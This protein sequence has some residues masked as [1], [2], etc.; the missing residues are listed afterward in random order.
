MDRKLLFFDIDGTL[1]PTVD[2]Q[3][4]ESTIQAVKKAQE[5]GH[6]IF[7]N[8]GRC[9][10][11]IPKQLKDIDFDGYL[12][13]CGTYVTLHGEVLT[14]QV[15]D[16]KRGRKL[17]EHARNLNLV[18]LP[19]GNDSC[20]FDSLGPRNP[21]V[22]FTGSQI[23]KEFPDK[24]KDLNTVDNLAFCKFCAIVPTKEQLQELLEPFSDYFEAIDRG[25]SFYEVVPIGYSKASAID[26]VID[27][28]GQS[29]DDCYVFGDSSNDLSML[30]HVKHSI[31]MGNSSEEVLKV[32]SYITTPVWRDG[33]YAA[34]KHFEL[35]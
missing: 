2:G 23:F 22:D 4:P 7:I 12:C 28:L 11:M 19:E 3:I 26:T 1:L 13:G 27:H 34:L 5:A 18:V 32:S 10:C 9:N 6:Y 16:Q 20:Y 17:V 31:A 30:T 14:N 29:L 15:F 33:I 35:I 25:D 24:L 21:W 8:T